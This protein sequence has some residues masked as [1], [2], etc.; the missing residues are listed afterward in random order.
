MVDSEILAEDNRDL[1]ESNWLLFVF[2]DRTH[3]CPTYAALILFGKNPR[4]YM[5]GAYVQFVRSDGKEKG[6]DVLNENVFRA[7]YIECFPP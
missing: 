3:D 7:R 2:Y 5:P 4:Y 1:K 6:G